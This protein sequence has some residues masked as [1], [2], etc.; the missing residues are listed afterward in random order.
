LE[1]SRRHHE[2]LAGNGEIELLHRLDVTQILLSNHC[3]RNV[4]DVDFVLS[5]QVKEQI[6]G[7]L[8]ILNTDLVGQLSLF[9]ALKLV[10]HKALYTSFGG[11]E[12]EPGLLVVVRQLIWI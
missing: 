12:Q 7:A 9:G 10:I 2:K 8:E 5:D 4:I 3:D 6:E 1:Q 11:D